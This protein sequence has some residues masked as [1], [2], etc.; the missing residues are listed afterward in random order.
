[1]H[2]I[3][4][5]PSQTELLYDLGLD[6][7]VIGITKFCIHPNEWFQN[8]TRVGGPKRLHIDTIKNLNPDLIIANKEENIKEEIEAC[9]EFCTVHVTDVS[10]YD[11]AL[12]MICEVGDITNR[13]KEAQNII[14]EIKSAFGGLK[15][16]SSQRVVYLIWKDPLMTIGGD[17]FINDMIE[18]IGWTNIYSKEKRYPQLTEEEF[19]CTRPDILLLSSEPYPFSEKHIPYFQ[20]LLPGTKILCV[21]GEPFCWYGS[22][23]RYAPEYFMKLDS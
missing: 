1:M 7:S 3:S 23:M 4:L 15:R 2:I 18:R 13:K 20:Q 21:E 12:K 16:K 6:E 5:V 14:L 22:R 11:E 10:N 19:V 8:K 17:T 9:R